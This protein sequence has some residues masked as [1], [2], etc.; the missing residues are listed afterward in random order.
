MQL[1]FQHRIATKWLEIDQDNLKPKLLALNVDFSCL[2]LDPLG[3]R[4]PAQ[5][6]VKTLTPIK[7]VVILSQLSCVA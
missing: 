1:T 3:T 5:V 2:S 6:G 7:K 4:R